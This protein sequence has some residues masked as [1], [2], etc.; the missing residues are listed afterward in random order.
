MIRKLFVANIATTNLDTDGD[1]MDPACLQEMK[2]ALKD[3]MAVNMNF[4]PSKPPIGFAKSARLTKAGRLIVKGYF[5]IGQARQEWD[6]QVYVVPGFV[7]DEADIVKNSDGTRLLKK[8][9]LTSLAVTLTPTDETLTP[10]RFTG[11]E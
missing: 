1:K 4:D 11:E 2:A 3:G 6:G 7:F 9:R 8:A 10:L 5:F